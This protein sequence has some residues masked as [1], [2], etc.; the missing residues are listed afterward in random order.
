MI[1][2]QEIR[3]LILDCLSKT[4]GGAWDTVISVVKE[5]VNS[6]GRGAFD[7]AVAD[8]I[9]WDLVSERLATFG[10]EDGNAAA[11]WPFIIL[12]PLG[13][14]VHEEAKPH[15]LDPEGYIKLLK[16]AVPDLE[17]VTSQYALEG[18]RCYRQN[19]LFAAAVM[20]GAA[21]ETQ[22]FG[23]LQ[24]IHDW[25]PDSTQ[26]QDLS[27]TLSRRRLPAVFERI[28]TATDKV[29]QNKNM[30]Y[31][32]HQGAH[33]HLL[34]LQEMVRIQRNEAIHPTVAEIDRHKVF[35]SIQTFPVAV[36]V[37]NRIRHWFQ[38][39]ASG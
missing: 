33:R 4:T 12:T 18:L 11:K 10:S 7:K 38:E 24:A 8:R 3:V 29:I 13:R 28:E 25:E 30:P 5:K 1:P 22:I 19:L 2:E 6:D 37:I 31:S 15:Y 17:D 9:L 16:E 32:V 14:K 26:K 23:L 21:A 39:N 27:E 36:E 20:I 35:L 34:S